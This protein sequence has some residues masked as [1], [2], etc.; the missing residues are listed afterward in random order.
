[1]LPSNRRYAHPVQPPRRPPW[2]R[3]RNRRFCVT[4]FSASPATEGAK[5]TYLCSSNAH[6]FAVL[7]HN[8]IPVLNRFGAGVRAAKR[9]L[10]PI[11]AFGIGWLY[12]VCLR[13]ILRQSLA[14]F[15][16]SRIRRSLHLP[17]SEE[18][19]S[20]LQSLRHLVCRLL[21]E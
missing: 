19:T 21:L 12:P 20:E 5:S 17:R 6:D 14:Q 8:A 10:P 11:P 9:G 3:P 15:S 16:F 18:H 4:K 13:L 1:M 2:R 7:R